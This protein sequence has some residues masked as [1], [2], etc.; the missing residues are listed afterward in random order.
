[1]EHTRLLLAALLAV[2]LPAAAQVLALPRAAAPAPE[3]PAAPAEKP[4]PSCVCSRHDYKPL[5]AK[6]TAA[7]EYWDARGKAK[8]SRSV[9]GIAALFGMLA[10]S[11]S[12]L[13]A[14]QET[15]S[16]A[17][18]ELYTARAA[19]VAAGAVKVEGEDFEEESIEFLLVKGVD[20][21]LTP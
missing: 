15:Y 13:N 17:M 18:G 5:T 6:G 10:Q 4:E 19:A 20:Y 11:G 14:A 16:R 1:M 3:A 9:S 7:K 12:A 2:P 8:I 21:R